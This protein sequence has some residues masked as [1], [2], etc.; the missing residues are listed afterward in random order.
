MFGIAPI[1]YITLQR[2]YG[3]QPLAVNYQLGLD[4]L[5]VVC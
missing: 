1:Y 5:N 4:R 2:F 3:C